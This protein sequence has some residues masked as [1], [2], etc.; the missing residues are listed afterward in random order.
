MRIQVNIFQV[1]ISFFLFIAGSGM[2][3]YVAKEPVRSSIGYGLQ[4]HPP[5][6]QQEDACAAG[7]SGSDLFSEYENTFHF[8]RMVAPAM[9]RPPQPI[10]EIWDSPNPAWKIIWEQ[11][12]WSFPIS[13]SCSFLSWINHPVDTST[14]IEYSAHLLLYACDCGA[15]Y[16]SPLV[17]EYSR[18]FLTWPSLTI[19]CI[20]SRVQVSMEV[21]LTLL[22]LHACLVRG[23]IIR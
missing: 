11:H 12:P 15:D 5:L 17:K 22:V 4:K 14:L 13:G 16:E 9:R 20:T 1:I 7:S 19:R 18:N 8:K 23:K 3:V 6:G 2:S 21:S 10:S